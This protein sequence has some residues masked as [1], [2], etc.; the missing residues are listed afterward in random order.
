M[1]LHKRRHL[2]SKDPLEHQTGTSSRTALLSSHLG[3]PN[4]HAMVNRSAKSGTEP[5]GAALL[6]ELLRRRRKR[7]KEK[8]ERK[9]RKRRR[10]SNEESGWRVSVVAPTV[11][12]AASNGQSSQSDLNG[13]PL[14]QPEEDPALPSQPLAERR[15][16]DNGVNGLRVTNGLAKGIEKDLVPSAIAANGS[17]GTHNDKV[18]TRIKSKSLGNGHTPSTLTNGSQHVHKEGKKHKRKH[19]ASPLAQRLQAERE[20][21]PIY[22]AQRAITDEIMRHQSVVIVGETGSGKTT[23]IPQFL[24]AAGLTQQ[25]IIA[26]TQPRRVAAISIAKRVADELGTKLG[27][28]VGYSIRFDDTTSPSTK[29]KYMTDGMLLRELLSDNKLKRYSAIILDEAHERTLRTDILF[30]M[31]K[32]IQKERKDLKI[33]I[34]SA[35]LNA[36][37]F[38]QYFDNAKVIYVAGRQFPVR[39]FAAVQRQE[40]YVD[41]ALVATFQLHMEEPRGDILVFLTGQEEI[42]NLQKLIE[43]NARN[44]PPKCPKIIV[45]P[46][47]AK[48]PADQQA[49]VFEPT[50]PG[51]R[52]IILSTNV[53]ETSITISGIRYVVDTGMAKVRSYNSK[54]GMESLVVQPISKASA[55]QRSGRA[56]REAPGFC[57]RLY[58]EEAF[59]SLPEDSEPEIMRCN[60][61]SVILLLKA[62]GVDDVVGFDYMDRPS[63]DSIIRALEQLYA[64]GALNDDGRLSSLGRQMAEL[65][66]DPVYSKILIQSKAFKCTKEVISI[67]AM[68]SV[69]LVFYTP[70]DKREQAGQARKRFMNYDGDHITLYNVLK[71]YQSVHGDAGWCTE[72]FISGRSLKQA[73]DIRKQLVTFAERM[74]IDTSVSCGTDFDPIL[75]CFLTGCFQNV[76]LRTPTGEY[77][78]MIGNQT[79]FIHPSS[80]LFGKKPVAVLYNELMHTTRQYMRNISVIQP[81][82]LLECAPQYYGRGEAPAAR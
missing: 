6:E 60:L 66:L 27:D 43:E 75:K 14:Q 55:R 17:S 45:T 56:G 52:K 28:K 81:Q 42:D 24:D 2:N 22:K 15:T 12:G 5:N 64:L 34:M 33:I 63:R 77:K 79:V 39:T 9:E 58:S 67:I 70:N 21:L 61:A 38:S 51:T 25:G 48:L 30:G 18:K 4:G 74:G 41:A 49:K 11:G 23:Q 32:A 20:A 69:D 71:G 68:L 36:E 46:I 80:V 3:R 72:N 47:Y 16:L 19:Q 26:I 31:V 37:R 10:E 76:A 82:W 57:Y 1:G 53:A 54:I 78:T 8:K 44:L 29:I 40:D 13:Q 35:T 59:D 50:P 73:L 7:R 65:P 62:S